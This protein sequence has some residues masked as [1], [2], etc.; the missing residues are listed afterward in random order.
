MF[1]NLLKS[2]LCHCSTRRLVRRTLLVGGF[3][4]LIGPILFISIDALIDN[5]WI[6][7]FLSELIVS[8]FKPIIY[9]KY[10]FQG[11]SSNRSY[12]ASFLVIVWGFIAIAIASSLTH[13]PSYR[14]I[15]AVG[16][17]LFGNLVIVLA[18]SL[19]K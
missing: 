14:R 1:P 12:I 15:F 16:I 3:N 2:K 11:F 19:L 4:S 7:Y 6:S 8:S 17:A 10:V 9:S 5:L 13:D 18:R